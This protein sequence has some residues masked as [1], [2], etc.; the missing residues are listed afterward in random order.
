MQTANFQKCSSTQGTAN[1]CEWEMIWNK[2]AVEDFRAENISPGGTPED[3]VEDESM[4]MPA[5]VI[6]ATSKV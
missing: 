1:V 2:G 4:P 5:L 6:A 3:M